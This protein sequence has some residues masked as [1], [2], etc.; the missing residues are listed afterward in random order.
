MALSETQIAQAQALAATG[1]SDA[2]IAAAIGAE[3]GDV[4]S[5]TSGANAAVGQAVSSVGGA[6]TG[7][8]GP[9]GP[10]GPPGPPGPVAEV[11]KWFWGDTEPPPNIT[12]AIV[13]DRYLDQSNGD[14][15]VLNSIDAS[16]VQSWSKQ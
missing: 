13:D 3:I 2:A 15:W 6:G 12:G 8:V 11:A 1:L 14:F 4:D 5:V 10:E 7:L 16:G 9:P